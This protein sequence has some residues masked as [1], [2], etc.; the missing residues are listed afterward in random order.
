MEFLLSF[1][2]NF[3]GFSLCR[4]CQ[5]NCSFG[6]LSENPLTILV[7]L[8]MWCCKR[9]IN[10]LKVDIILI[11]EYI[12]YVFLI[13]VVKGF[14]FVM[15]MASIIFRQ[16]L[17]LKMRIKSVLSVRILSIKVGRLLCYFKWGT[18]RVVFCEIY[19]QLSW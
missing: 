9:C 15:I 19:G 8:H 12:Q 18:Y 13:D 17:Q 4:K 5:I 2:S 1:L 3:L 6:A 10:Y 11:S 16:F 7:M 14:F